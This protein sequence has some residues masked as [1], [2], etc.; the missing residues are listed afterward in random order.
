MSII[1]NKTVLRPVNEE[2]LVRDLS[3]FNFADIEIGI[4]HDLHNITAKILFTDQNP[5]AL[6]NLI[7]YVSFCQKNVYF[8]GRVC[9]KYVDGDLSIHTVSYHDLS[10]MH[11][12]EKNNTVNDI[13]HNY[14]GVPVV[15]SDLEGIMIK[16]AKM[17]CE[18]CSPPIKFF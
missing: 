2:E 7:T 10:H 16:V 13:W 6:Y 12:I 1:L 8:I 11:P 14:S 4:V 18:S 3:I 15:F 9:T 17:L 5:D